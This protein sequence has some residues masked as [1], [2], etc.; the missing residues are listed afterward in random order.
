MENEILQGLRLG[1]GEYKHDER[2]LMLA[3]YVLPDIR[4]PAKHDF[5]RGRSPIPVRV[6]G[7]ND[8]GNCVIAGEANHILRNERVEQRRTVKLSDDHVINRYKL[9]T[10]TQSPGDS[11][12][13]GL[14]VLHTMRDWRGNG[15]TVDKRNYSISA[16]GELQPEDDKQLRS[17]IYL[18]NGIHMGVWLPRAAQAMT[19][20]GLWDYNGETG[21]EWAPGSWGGHLVYAK[22]YDEDSV[23]VLTWGKEVKVSNSFIHK[24]CDEA[25]GV[26]DNFNAWKTRQTIDVEKLKKYLRDIGAKVDA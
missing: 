26:V 16:F 9:L 22:K 18:L 24:Y 20:N 21:A 25:W 6:W 23:S 14:V 4:I 8:Y 2:T 7:N 13:N 11:N 3:R 10:G 19:N 12:D 15:F 5:D 1:K 17:A